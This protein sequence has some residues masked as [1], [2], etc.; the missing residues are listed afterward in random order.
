MLSQHIFF[1]TRQF[2]YPTQ[3]RTSTWLT[4]YMKSNNNN[5]QPQLDM[6]VS[7]GQKMLYRGK[8]VLSW[9]PVA[10]LAQ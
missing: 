3:K 10:Q 9:I 8:K 7:G 2:L 4:N 6:Q 5:L 1:K